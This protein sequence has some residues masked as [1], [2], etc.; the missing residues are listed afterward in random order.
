MILLKRMKMIIK[1]LLKDRN[2]EFKHFQLKMVKKER[3]R[4]TLK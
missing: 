3:N 1:N 2:L 4:K